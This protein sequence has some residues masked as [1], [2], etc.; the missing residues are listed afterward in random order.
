MSPE[1]FQ[2][3]L[4]NCGR[5]QNKS[6]EDLMKPI[7]RIYMHPFWSDYILIYIGEQHFCSKKIIALTCF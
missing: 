3:Q 7:S 5:L 1:G 4:I 2:I 6:G